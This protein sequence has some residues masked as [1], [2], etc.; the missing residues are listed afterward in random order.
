MS[1]AAQQ[2]GVRVSALRFWEMQGLLQPKRD[3]DNRYRL[4][5]EDEL[6]KLRVIVLL[7]KAN[8]D[9]AAIHALLEQ[10]A[11]GTTEQALAAADMR[12]HELAEASRRCIAAT[13]RLW[14][15]IEETEAIS[16]G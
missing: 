3:H 9:F 8:Y 4:Y 6:R 15:Y 12:L 13:T 5:Y 10:L 2:V 11:S 1:E 16:T 7:R 14:A